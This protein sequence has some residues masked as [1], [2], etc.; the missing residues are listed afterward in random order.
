MVPVYISSALLCKDGPHYLK[1]LTSQ[2][3][4]IYVSDDL[5][6]LFR[7]PHNSKPPSSPNHVSK[8]NGEKNEHPNFYDFTARLFLSRCATAAC[9]LYS[10]AI[11]L[12]INEWSY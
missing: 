2:Y 10:T 7:I 12:T 8:I 9:P 4:T 1:Y 5:C 6:F 3:Y 11:Y